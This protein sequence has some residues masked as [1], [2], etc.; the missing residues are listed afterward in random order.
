MS[1]QECVCVRERG[2][3]KREREREREREERDREGERG[4]G[5]IH[6][7]LCIFN[8]GR[9]ISGKCS[10][11][12]LTRGTATSAMRRAERPYGRARYSAGAGCSALK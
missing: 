6:R 3:E 7:C 5:G 2:G 4:P 12:R 8:V 9:L 10:Q 11:E 1:E